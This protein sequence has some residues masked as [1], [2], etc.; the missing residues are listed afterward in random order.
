M[1]LVAGFVLTGF[2][3]PE[4]SN[5]SLV[6]LTACTLA[7]TAAGETVALRAFRSLE[8]ESSGAGVAG[9]RARFLAVSAVVSCAAFAM[10]IL[11]TAIPRVLMHPCD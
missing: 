1:D 2:A 11:A 9:E 7:A 4:G 5:A 6:A 8:A 3:C 10:V